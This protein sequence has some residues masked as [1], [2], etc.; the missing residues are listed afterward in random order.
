MIYDRWSIEKLGNIENCKDC[1][2]TEKVKQK[3][4]KE[5]IKPYV[6]LFYGLKV[7]EKPKYMFIMQNPGIKRKNNHLSKEYKEEINTISKGETST[8]R[9]DIMR[10]QWFEWMTNKN[11]GFFKVFLNTMNIFNQE[12]N[13]GFDSYSNFFKHFYVTDVIKCRGDTRNLAKYAGNRC[14]KN[15]LLYEI[16]TIKPKLIFTFSVRA[17]GVFAPIIKGNNKITKVHGKHFPI[18]VGTVNT[19]IIPLTHFTGQT[20]NNC[21]RK[22]Y[23][24]YFTEGLINFLK[25][26][27]PSSPLIKKLTDNIYEEQ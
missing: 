8:R 5:N 3:H 22:S 2:W 25:L 11:K 14:Y 7:G 16:N 13:L 1:G 26:D 9:M 10:K 17:W 21:L 12:L 19:H 20:Y 15:F 27:D 24:N 18:L 23:F 6:T 4:K